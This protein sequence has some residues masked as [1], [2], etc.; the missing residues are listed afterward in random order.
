MKSTLG[1]TSTTILVAGL[2]SFCAA[3]I[4]QT[5]P[6]TWDEAALASMQTPLRDP[7]RTPK[8]MSSDTYNRI[9]LLI[10]YK[11]YP[12]YAP[13]R[14]PAGYI[15]RLR[16]LEPEIVVQP[17]RLQTPSDWARAGDA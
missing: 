7:S 12:V 5:I 4:G 16:E 8:H 14:E 1:K 15:E 10:V 13:G 2:F 11:T 3:A 9:P 6:I 17:D